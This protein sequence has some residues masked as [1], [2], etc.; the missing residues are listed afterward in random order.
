MVGLV[1]LY[2]VGKAFYDLAGRNN[3]S[4]WLYAILGVGSY[5]AGLFGG[6]ILI[7]IGYDLF[8]GSIDEVNDT[9]LGFLGLPFGVLLCWGYYRLLE[10]RWEKDGTV[11]ASA[12]ESLGGHLIDRD[13]Q[14][15]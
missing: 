5:Y 8:I 10:G 11:P 13:S 12:E 1:V 9:L 14:R 3:K 7:A 4:E 15:P 2:L 6:G